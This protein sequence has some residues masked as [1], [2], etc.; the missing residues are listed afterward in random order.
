MALDNAALLEVLEAMRAAGV[1]DRVRTAAKT[2][3][4]AMIDAELTSVIGAGPWERIDERTAQRNSRS[5]RVAARKQQQQR[6]RSRQ[7][8]A[9]AEARDRAPQGKNV[10]TRD[11]TNDMSM[12]T[13]HP[14][15]GM[16][17]LASQEPQRRRSYANSA[18]YGM[19]DGD[20]G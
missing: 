6:D 12:F 20:E 14:Y 2:I 18:R 10:V 1:E 7:A 11:G 4:Q 16:E 5:Y 15:A 9:V 3:Y 8:V 17:R 13:R 19:R